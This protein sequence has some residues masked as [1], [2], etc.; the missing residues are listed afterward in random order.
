M[1]A[2]PPRTVETL[3]ALFPSVHRERV[4]DAVH[5]H[6]SNVAQAVVCLCALSVEQLGGAVDESADEQAED[7]MACAQALASADAEF[8]RSLQ[9]AIRDEARPGL[10][11]TLLR[12][13]PHR[14]LRAARAVPM[15]PESKDALPSYAS[16]SP[17]PGTSPRSPLSRRSTPML[18]EPLLMESVGGPRP[19]SATV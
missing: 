9:R 15:P 13:C 8:F 14:V 2:A 5:E 1:V 18:K 16:P 19:R 17:S 11:Q 12:S 6:K 4:V 7:D 10:H 3:S